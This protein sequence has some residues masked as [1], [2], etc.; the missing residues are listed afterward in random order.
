M[1]ESRNLTNL[2]GVQAQI[3]A[4][5]RSEPDIVYVGLN[6]RDPAWH[7]LY[8]VS[9]S[10]GA[11]QLVRE[12]KDRMSGLVFDREDQLRL[13]VRTTNAGDTEILRIDPAGP[14]KI[15]E[16]SVFE[17]CGPASF[18]KDG[19][20]VYIVT[21]KGDADLIHL[22]LLDV[23]TGKVEA[24]ESDP[25]KRVDLGQPLFSQVTDELVGTTYRDD[26]MRVYFRDPA[27]KADYA[28]LQDKFPDHEIATPSTTRDEQLAV[29]ALTSD[30]EPGLYYLFDRRT[31]QL[32]PQFKVR[33]DLPRESLASMRPIRY[34]SSDGLE[35]PGYLAL[36]KGAPAKGLPLIVL[37]H[38]GPNAREIW[39]YNALAQFLANRGFAVLVPNFRGS[40]GYGKRFLNAGNGQWG[41]KMQDDVTW[42]VRHLVTEGIADPKRV[43]ILGA[44]Y[45]G[46]AALAGV[47]FTPDLYAAAV[48]IVPPSNIVTLLNS[49]RTGKPVAS[50]STLAWPIRTRLRARRSS[51]ASL[52]S[53]LLTGSARRC[54][55]CKAQTILASTGSS[56]TRS[57]S[58][59]VS[60]SFPWSTLSRR[61][62]AMASRSPS[63]LSRC[64]RPR[65]SFW[66]DTFEAFVI[67]KTW[68]LRWRSG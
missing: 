55:W 18:H 23:T 14:T 31:K 25:E 49:I 51:R 47:A 59:C 39:R 21:N 28:L 35:I 60:G 5:P 56:P 3:V 7:D 44:S 26:R 65:R 48:A 9:L 46:Y 53:T 45:G 43:A 29:I 15:Y 42:G 1:P 6:N 64:M 38:G 62:K 36:P 22:A 58:R 10:T 41:E 52:H 16:C 8:R 11:R 34:R 12:N 27:R 30:V 19:R 2:A 67:R 50:S 57:S 54:L 66:Q 4:V 13:A 33:D 40:T 68:R 61:M 37:P 24:V 63:T 17:S 32:T 20:R